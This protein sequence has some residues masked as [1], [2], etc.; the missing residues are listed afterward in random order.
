MGG[1]FSFRA[2]LNRAEADGGA[3]DI[4]DVFSTHPRAQPV[5]NPQTAS[6]GAVHLSRMHTVHFTAPTLGGGGF[7]SAST[8]DNGNGA[9]GVLQRKEWSRTTTA[10]TATLNMPSTAMFSPRPASDVASA[11]S[12]DTSQACH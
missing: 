11:D 7:V 10:S 3:Q 5:S 8:T 12:F 4:V 6:G 1:A 2:A 9:S